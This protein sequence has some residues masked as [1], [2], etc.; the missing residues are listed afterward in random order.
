M[1]FHVYLLYPEYLL[2]SCYQTHLGKM[3]YIISSKSPLTNN[4]SVLAVLK[5]SSW[6]C[7]KSLKH[8]G[9]FSPI[10]IV[11]WNSSFSSRMIGSFSLLLDAEA[12]W[13]WSDWVGADWLW[14]DW[15]WGFWRISSHSSYSLPSP[16]WLPFC[17]LLS[18]GL[19]TRLFWISA[20]RFPFA[21]SQ[22]SL[23]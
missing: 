21:F 22:A 3:T 9:V 1:L 23:I 20:S 18:K 2:I 4:P 11:L 12:D 14:G 16:D 8:S 13:L 15:V 5:D 6:Y 19:V 10:V 17:H 7:L